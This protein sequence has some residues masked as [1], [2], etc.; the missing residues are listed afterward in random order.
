MFNLF[1]QTLLQLLLASLAF[2]A[3]LTA[4]GHHGTPPWHYG[5]G[6]GVAGFIVLV[7]DIIVWSTS[8]HLPCSF[9]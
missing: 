6:G 3:P 1:L 9:R 7:L 2:A 8:S 5:V 4:Q